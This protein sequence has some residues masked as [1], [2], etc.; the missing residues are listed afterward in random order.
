[1][2]DVW[3]ARGEPQKAAGFFEEQRGIARELGD[4]RGESNALRNLGDVWLARGEPQKAAGFF[5]EQRG[6]ARELELEQQREQQRGIARLW[7][8]DRRG[9][10]DASPQS[11][12]EVWLRERGVCL[13]CGG[14]GK[15]DGKSCARCSGSGQVRA[16]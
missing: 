10:A 3:L 4:R 5:E 12:V 14:T 8:G 2:G 1:M 13:L 16:W 11:A 9:Q 6:I 7:F 15:K